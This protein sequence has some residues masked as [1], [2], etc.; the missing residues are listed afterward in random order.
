[1]SGEEGLEEEGVEFE[2]PSWCEYLTGKM[3][4]NRT[5]SKRD[6]SKIPRQTSK[7]GLLN[8]VEVGRKQG[9]EEL[10]RERPF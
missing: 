10:G 1:M 8:F 2:P 9:R 7:R 6:L 3:D 4:V 5:Q